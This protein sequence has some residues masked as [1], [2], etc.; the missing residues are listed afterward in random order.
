MYNGPLHAIKTIAATEGI[1][2]LYKGYATVALTIPA[3]GLY[4]GV[5]Q[6]CKKLVPGTRVIFC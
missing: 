3:Q 2:T 5:Y 6:C 1:R 4:M